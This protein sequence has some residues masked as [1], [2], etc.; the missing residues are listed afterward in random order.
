MLQSAADGLA[1]VVALAL[2]AL[3]QLGN[4]LESARVGDRDR[5]VIGKYSQPIQV[6]LLEPTAAEERHHTQ[7][8]ALEAQ[9]LPG[10]ALNALG[11]GPIRVHQPVARATLEQEWAIVRGDVADLA[12]R[13]QDLLMRPIGAVPALGW[14]H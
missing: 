14:V 6:R 1:Q 7:H 2:G 4:F 11:V 3:L 9:R 5:S 8:L 12:V 13:Q 10:K